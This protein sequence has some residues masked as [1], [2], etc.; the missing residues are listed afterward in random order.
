MTTTKTTPL[1]R[2]A[3]VALLPGLTA[4]ASGAATEAPSPEA[5]A[6]QA[7]ETITADEMAQ[8]IG[9]LA[10][11]SMAGRDTPSPEL[12]TA[13]RYLADQFRSVGLTPAGDD[14]TYLHRWEYQVNRL[15][16]DA[17]AVR[18]DGVDGSAL[19]YG[20][21]FFLVPGMQEPTAEAVYAGVAGEAGP[22]PDYQGKIVI[23]DHPG[24]EVDTE[25]QQTLMA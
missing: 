3:A 16:D 14:G 15:D 19:D 9:V 13:A 24:A 23:L 17:T 4:C 11:D 21:D 22:S 25:W 5:A 10:H 12:E 18:L 8:E 7:V 20:V 6:H 2:L 1:A